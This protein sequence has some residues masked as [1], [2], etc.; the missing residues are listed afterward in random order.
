MKRYKQEIF[1]KTKQALIIC[2]YTELV[3]IFVKG[4]TILD[5]SGYIW[6]ANNHKVSIGIFW[7]FLNKKA[8]V[9]FLLQA[10]DPR[11]NK[12]QKYMSFRYVSFTLFYMTNLKYKYIQIKLSLLQLNNKNRK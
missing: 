1:S 11:E 6:A 8:S 9:A 12:N 5:F 7:I 2:L 10:L 4:I 3:S